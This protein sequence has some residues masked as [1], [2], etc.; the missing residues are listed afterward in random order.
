M[1]ERSLAQMMTWNIVTVD[2]DASLVRAAE[3][4]ETAHI[5]SVLVLALG[6]PVG[7]VTERDILRA[8]KTNVPPGQSV[9]T[10][11]GR[12]LVCAR[13][14]VTV[15]EAYH[16]MAD[17]HVRHLLVTDRDGHPAGIVSESDFRFHLRNAGGG[18]QAFMLQPSTEYLNRAFSPSCFD[19]FLGPVALGIVR[20]VP[21]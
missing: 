5:S 9:L 20:Q 18:Y 6:K 15:H 3:I 2:E 16:L 14:D 8:L 12:P 19:F 7:I 4:M 17:K 21:A 11:M 1:R 10:V 13:Q